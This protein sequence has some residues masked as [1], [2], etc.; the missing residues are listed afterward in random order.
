MAHSQIVFKHPSFGS[1]KPAPV[2]FSWTTLFFGFFP[3]LFRGDIK[4]AA[5][6]FLL[7]VVVGLVTAGFGVLVAAICFAVFYN[8]L[9]IKDL[10]AKGYQVQTLQSQYTLEQLQ[11]Q[12]EVVLVKAD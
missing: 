4:W 6:I 10:V 2:G 11:S 5:I 9:Y 7:S 8:K 1:L 3:A 12:L